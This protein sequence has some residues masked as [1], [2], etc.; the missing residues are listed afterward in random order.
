MSK[1]IAVVG[2]GAVGGYIGGFLAHGGHDV[3][4]IDPWPEHVETTR[5]NGMEL[6]GMSDAERLTVKVPIIHLTEVQYF[7]RQRPIDIAIVSVKSYDTGWAATMI[8]QYLAPDGYIVSAQNCIN[9]PRVA[10]VVGWGKTVGC[11]VGGGIGVELFQPGHI[12]RSYAKTGLQ[13]SLF[14][15]EVHG[16]ITPRIRE[17]A[18]IL[19]SVDAVSITTNL[20]GERWSK[21][22]VNIMRNAVSAATGLYGNERDRHDASRRISIKLGGEAVRVGQAL[23]YNF[24]HVGNLDAELLARALGDKGALEEI[25]TVMLTATKTTER[26]ELQ[27]PSMAQDIAKGR[28]TEIEQMNGFIAKCAIEIGITAPTNEMLTSLIKGIE[29][30]DIV[31]NPENLL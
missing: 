12:R 9:E 28:R 17:L 27:R 24:D 20:W 14:V 5:A 16:R 19:G 30:G 11:V 1:R 13:G 18:E 21:L 10:S 31:A 26:S 3:T 22:C 6:F 4:L 7:I 2:A 29:R 15:G 8:A 23:G 25:E